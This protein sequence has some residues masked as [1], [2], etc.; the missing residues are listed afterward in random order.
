MKAAPRFAWAAVLLACVAGAGLRSVMLGKDANWDLK[1]Y[2]WYDVWALFHGRHGLDVAPAQLQTWHNPLADVPF[3]FLVNA[4]SDPRWVAFWMA[5]PVAIAGFFLLRTLAVLYPFDRA[6]ANGALWIGAA[7]VVGITGA[8]GAATWGTTMNEWPPA[9]LTMAA[10]WV[11]VRAAVQGAGGTVEGRRAHLRAF[12]LAGFLVGCAV[13]VKL[14]YAVFAF[15]FLVACLAFGSVRERFAR[16]VVAGGFAALGFLACYGWWGWILW[17][18]FANPFFPYFNGLFRSPWWE[19]IDFFDRNFGPRDWRQ[20]IFFPW[21]FAQ[22]SL[23]VSEVSFRDWRL[24]T[25]LALALLAWLASRVRNLRE[26][27]NAPPPAPEPE[28]RGWVL[29]S[30]FTLASYVAWIKLYG[31][32]RYLVPLELVSGALIVGCVMY[33]F[34]RGRVQVA[35]V[36]VLAVLLVGTTRPGSWGRVAFGDRYFDVAPPAI[37]SDSLVIL[38]YRHPLAYAAP[39]FTPGVRFVSPVNNFLDLGQRNRLARAADEA[40][41]GHRGPRWFLSYKVRTP[42]DARTLAYF[43]LALEEAGCLVVPSSFDEDHLRLCPVT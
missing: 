10:I 42:H 40:I 31:I 1:N 41:R 15:G 5:L 20:W 23:L 37:P 34:P 35:I 26:N 33:V 16:A 32:Y 4:L 3:C 27:P 25:L 28:S 38:G 43:G 12:A 19:P 8:A 18:D 22:R 7:W 29:V 6:R 14:T 17:R 21:Y 30:V 13:G 36:L 2:H 24:A 9:A 11:A 39:F